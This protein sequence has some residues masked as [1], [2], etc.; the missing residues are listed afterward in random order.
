MEVLLRQNQNGY[1]IVSGHRRLK[2]ALDIK[3]EV[4]VV[5]PGIGKLLIFRNVEGKLFATNDDR[6]VEIFSS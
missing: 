1:I 5:A 6:T 2:A 3:A 4:G